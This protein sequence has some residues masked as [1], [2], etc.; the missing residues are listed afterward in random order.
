MAAPGDHSPVPAPTRGPAPDAKT[1]DK[2]SAKFAEKVKD[3]MSKVDYSANWAKAKSMFW[4]GVEVL[5]AVSNK[6]LNNDGKVEGRKRPKTKEEQQ[7]E[8]KK[9]HESKREEHE[10]LRKKWEAEKTKESSDAPAENLSKEEQ[11]VV[12][13]IRKL[14]GKD[15]KNDREQM[16]RHYDADRTGS[17][18]HEEV[19]QVVKAAGVRVTPSLAPSHS[20][21]CKRYDI[22]CCDACSSATC[23]RKGCTQ[24]NSWRSWTL[25]GTRL[26]SSP[27]FWRLWDLVHPGAFPAA[28]QMDQ[29][30][31]PV[32]V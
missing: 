13:K 32:D 12:R 17:L 23:S 5:E 31:G 11:E 18:S 14:L 26:C 7:A 4:K 2:F 15:F 28:L 25:T 16:F 8:W 29:K 20:C 19:R 27:R 30:A 24:R 21:M 3:R 22:S 10:K 1:K 6:D 9:E